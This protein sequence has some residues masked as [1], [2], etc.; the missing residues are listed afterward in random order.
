MF[1][2]AETSIQV[3]RRD[4]DVMKACQRVDCSSVWV[5]VGDG[6]EVKSRFWGEKMFSKDL[7]GGM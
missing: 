2:V 5:G 6:V 1:S 4:S 7:V 3:R